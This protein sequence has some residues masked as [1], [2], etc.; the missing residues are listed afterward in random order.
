KQ[1]YKPKHNAHYTV[2]WGSDYESGDDESHTNDEKALHICLMASISNNNSSDD[3]IN[4]SDTSSQIEKEETIINPI[5]IWKKRY[6][7]SRDKVD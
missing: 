7:K 1:S 6:L 4:G 2:S 3:S 5:D